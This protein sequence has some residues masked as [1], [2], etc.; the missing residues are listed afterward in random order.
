VSC[1]AGCGACCRHLVAVTP[2]EAGS[3]MRLVESLPTAERQAIRAG[4]AAAARAIDEVG[5]RAEVAG[6][7]LLALAAL[8]GLAARYFHLGIPC[9]FLQDERCAV[10]PHRP[11]VCR[12]YIVTSPPEECQTPGQ[13]ELVPVPGRLFSHLGRNSNNGPAWVPLVLAPEWVAEHPEARDLSPRC[14]GPELLAEILGANGVTHQSQSPAETREPGRQRSGAVA[15]LDQAGMLID[16]NAWNP[17]TTSA[18]SEDGFG[19]APV[20][21][22]M[23]NDRERTRRYLVAIRQT[24]QPGD[25]VV[26]LG[27]GSGVLAVAAAQAGASR[28]YAIEA[29]VI[30]RVA[31]RVFEANGVADRITLIEGHS[32]HIELPERADVLV[33]ELIGH[34]P[35]GEGILEST[36]DAVRR[37]LKPDA[38]LIPCRLRVMAVPVELPTIVRDRCRG[39]AAMLDLWHQETGIDFTPLAAL[40]QSSPIHFNE[41]ATAVAAW[42]TLAEPEV[43]SDFD[44]SR[45]MHSPVEPRAEFTATRDG[46]VDGFVLWFLADLSNGNALATD[47]RSPRPDNHWRHPVYVLAAPAEV[48][49]GDKVRFRLEGDRDRV[50][51]VSIHSQDVPGA[52]PNQLPLAP[53][54]GGQ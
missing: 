51:R 3:L 12:E 13:I 24:V 30:A 1:R 6:A 39:S 49:C 7:P 28:V 19:S 8:R 20:H 29:T 36:A 17:S 23:L 11:L 45:L 15:R 26:D 10:Y 22:A 9:P 25:V 50:A 18:D 33:A 4:F 48:R 42:G 31:R 2:F 16:G 21:I 44:L 53:G 32:T 41:K 35:L 47:P 46:R 27:T 37:F 43:V 5:L 34:E 38:R 14:K 54:E 52:L 40:A